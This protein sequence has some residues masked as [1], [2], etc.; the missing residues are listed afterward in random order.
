[1]NMH[2]LRFKGSEAL[3]ADTR[4]FLLKAANRTKYH[5]KIRWVLYEEAR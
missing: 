1:M 2:D 5:L 4:S 3:S